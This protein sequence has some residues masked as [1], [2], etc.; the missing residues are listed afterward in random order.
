MARQLRRQ[1]ETEVLEG[2]VNQQV[3]EKHTSAGFEYK[4]V[5]QDA[6]YMVYFP[7]GHSIRIRTEAELKRLGFDRGAQLV[8][9]ETGEVVDEDA[10]EGSLKDKV[11]SAG[12][13]SRQR[14]KQRRAGDE[15][16]DDLMEGED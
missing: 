1:F 13:R 16:L 5:K 10:S 9:M 11:Q 3:I 12:A 4:T 7:K 14:A 2:E 6:G 8:D 15:T